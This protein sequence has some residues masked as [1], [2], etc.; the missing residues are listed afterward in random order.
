MVDRKPLKMGETRVH[1][2]Y[3]GKLIPAYHL[4]TTQQGS[5][6]GLH[7][8]EMADWYHSKQNDSTICNILR[9]RVDIAE[10][11]TQCSGCRRLA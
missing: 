7:W 10:L 6:T 9:I 8:N 4:E 5:H 11:H 3:E 2:L 1:C